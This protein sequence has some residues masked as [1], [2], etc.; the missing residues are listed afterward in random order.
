MVETKLPFILRRERAPVTARD[1][2]ERGCSKHISLHE[3]K[4]FVDRTIDVRFRRE[5][6]HGHRLI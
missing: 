6:Q 2:Q 3:R 4:W 5:M 1:L